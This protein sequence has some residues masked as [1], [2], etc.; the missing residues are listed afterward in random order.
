MKKYI[1]SLFYISIGTAS[2][3]KTEIE[4]TFAFSEDFFDDFEI[5]AEEILYELETPEE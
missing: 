1:T 4:N 5:P 3:L 2:I